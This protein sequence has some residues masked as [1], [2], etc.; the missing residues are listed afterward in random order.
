[1]QDSLVLAST[2]FAHGQMTIDVSKIT[3][4]QFIHGKVGPTRSVGLWLSGFVSFDLQ[5]FQSNLSKVERFCYIEKNFQRPVLQEN[6][7]GA[8]RRQIG[9][10]QDGL[11]EGACTALTGKA[12][13]AGRGEIEKPTHSRRGKAGAGSC[14]RQFKSHSFEVQIRTDQDWPGL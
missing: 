13:D 9:A 6:R 1:V 3:C 7:A 4:D 8:R 5:K 2:S 11:V 14:D 12:A 10:R